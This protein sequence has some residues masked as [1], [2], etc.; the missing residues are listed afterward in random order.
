[1]V[2][3]EPMFVMNY[4]LLLFFIIISCIVPNRNSSLNDNIYYRDFESLFN[5]TWKTEDGELKAIFSGHGNSK[6]IYNDKEYPITYFEYN[7]GIFIL[8]SDQ[9]QY[10]DCWDL[11][12]ILS[13]FSESE[14][15]FQLYSGRSNSM[16]KTGKLEKVVDSLLML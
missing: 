5:T 4:I 1:M 14:F 2:H 3:K 10:S 16:D 15:F 13:P 12:L 8:E 6:I 9:I 11:C 7:D